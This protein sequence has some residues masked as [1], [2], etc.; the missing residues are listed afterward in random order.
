MSRQKRVTFKL[1]FRFRLA[2]RRARTSSSACPPTWLRNWNFICNC[3]YY[4]KKPLDEYESLMLELYQQ[5]A[6]SKLVVEVLS[7]SKH[8][9]LSYEDGLIRIEEKAPSVG[10]RL[11]SEEMLLR[12]AHSVVSQVCLGI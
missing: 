10:I 2:T 8:S 12:H 4:L 6:L 1:R 3:E 5:T 7:Q 11:F 9:D